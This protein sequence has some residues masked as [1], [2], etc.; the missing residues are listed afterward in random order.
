MKQEKEKNILKA[1]E[2]E[3]RTITDAE[4][5]EYFIMGKTRIKITEHFPSTGKPIDELVTDLITHKM[6]E[7]AGKPA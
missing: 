5:A 4:G 1:P 3:P 6:R 2:E 7:K